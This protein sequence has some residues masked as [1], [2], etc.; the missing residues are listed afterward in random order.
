MT[1]PICIQICR[2]L[3]LKVPAHD[4][5]KGQ[6]EDLPRRRRDRGKRFDDAQAGG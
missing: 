3:G 4:G 5:L 2:T 6:H 1:N